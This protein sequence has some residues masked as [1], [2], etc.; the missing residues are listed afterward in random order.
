[1]TRF[2]KLVAASLIVVPASIA[3]CSQPTTDAPGAEVQLPLGNTPST[4]ASCQ[5]ACAAADN[6]GILANYG[7]SPAL[8]EQVC[9]ASFTEE[10]AQ[11]AQTAS[12]SDLED[13]I[14]NGGAPDPCQQACDKLDGCGILSA[15][16]MS[17]GECLTECAQFDAAQVAFANDPNTTCSTLAS[18]LG[19][20]TTTPCQDACAH[21]DNCGLLAQYGLDLTTCDSYCESNLDPQA[22]DHALT[23]TCS[24]LADFIQNGGQVPTA[25]CDDLCQKADGC[26]VLAQLGA[27]INVCVSYCQSTYSQAEIDAAMAMSC[28]ELANNAP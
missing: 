4:P 1:M 13:A 24:E 16:N 9:L 23:L 28:T 17:V 25:T 11:W 8:C 21:A 10:D 20:S 5:A 6:C 12:C 26:G 15:A 2:A 27:S 19:V 22:V 3:A 7:V 18:L 14:S